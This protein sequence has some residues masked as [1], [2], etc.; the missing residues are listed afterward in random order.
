MLL[1]LRLV[2]SLRMHQTITGSPQRLHH[3]CIRQSLPYHHE[4]SLGIAR[5]LHYRRDQRRHGCIGTLPSCPLGLLKSCISRDT[6]RL[7]N[8]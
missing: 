3:Q 4:T 2:M 8:R 5:H 1:L 7:Q 6:L